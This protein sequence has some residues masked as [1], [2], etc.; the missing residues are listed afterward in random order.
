MKSKILIW[1]I[2]VSLFAAVATPAGLAGQE[3]QKQ[4]RHR[5]RF[6]DVGTFGGPV[7]YLS[8]DPS[9][10]GAAA[11]VLN[12]RGRVV[13]AA[14]T[15]MPDPNYPNTCLV[16]PADPLIFH[17]FQW[18]DGVLT[19]LGALPGVNS[20]FSNW[21]SPRGLV[22]GFSENGATDP[23]LGVPE[24]DAVLWKDGEI[25]DLGT[26]EGGYESNAFAVNDRG[27]VAGVFVNTIPDPFSPFGLQVRAF[28]WQGGAMED[29][30][31]LGGPE[32][33]A[34]FMNQRG[35]VVGNSFLNSIP[36]P[37]TG[38]PTLDPFVWEDGKMIDLGTLGGTIGTPNAMNNRGWVA[39]LSNLAGD[40]VYHPFLWDGE[41]MTDLGTFGGDLGQ[42]NWINEAGEVVGWATNQDQALFAFLWKQGVLT[43]LGTLKG[44]TCSAALGINSKSQVVG[45]SAKTCTFTAADRHASLWENGHVID[46]NT[47]LPPSAELQLTD[48][49][50]I[51]DRGEI[52]GLGVP[53]GCGDEFACGRVFVLLPCDD[54]QPDE[55][56]CEGERDAIAA[57][58][59]NSHAPVKQ[60]SATV[61]GGGLTPREIADR[62][63]ARFGRNRAFGPLPRKPFP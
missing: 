25:V 7:G 37:S 12:R 44:E 60:S 24:I 4:A 59:Q 23:L 9:G 48:A 6:V 38:T 27:Q 42:A 51:N 31:T 54:D 58:I 17:A 49:Y 20:S 13:S 55:K 36:N 40:L 22:A 57:A 11:G 21:I 28:L 1:T 3:Q 14:D 46:L 18:H 8:N 2:A 56:G 10:G 47:F 53:P 43:N 33:S 41:K 61:R 5:Y 35:Q 52:A 50:N 62:M 30:G 45:L 32:A 15:A 34:Y 19:D 16:C 26:I 63:Q 29:L 39:G